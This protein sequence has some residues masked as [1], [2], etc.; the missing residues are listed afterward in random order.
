MQTPGPRPK[1]RTEVAAPPRKVAQAE[2][3][4]VRLGATGAGLGCSQIVCW[5]GRAQTVLG[6]NP[7]PL[8][9]FACL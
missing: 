6:S 1:A 4:W 3:V 8:P 5:G 2:H 7:A 9:Q